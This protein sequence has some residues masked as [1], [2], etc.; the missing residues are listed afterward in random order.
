M[1]K[2]TTLFTASLFTLL[3]QPMAVASECPLI[4]NPYLPAYDT[5]SARSTVFEQNSAI[6]LDTLKQKSIDTI[7]SEELDQLLNC[8]RSATKLGD[9]IAALTLSNM[10]IQLAQPTD[11]T[12]AYLTRIIA[13]TS[14]QYNV[15]ADLKRLFQ[16]V[17]PDNQVLAMAFKD[18]NET[19]FIEIFS[20]ESHLAVSDVEDLQMAFK[21][22][23]D[24]MPAL[25]EYLLN[26]SKKGSVTEMLG[27]I[28]LQEHSINYFKTHENN[29]DDHLIIADYVVNHLEYRPSYEFSKAV[30]DI[31]LA[32][33]SDSQ[34]AHAKTQLQKLD[35]FF[36]QKHQ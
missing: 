16:R 3:L 31:A 8:L 35:D 10:L 9:P 13:N 26:N 2:M 22:N 23:W 1:K 28:A 33:G 32:Q 19:D 27:I 24:N 12:E 25:A 7:S 29:L 6:I 4:D 18:K 5:K 34:K 36:T 30:Y 17:G 11:L 14:L 15:M 20:T 21:D